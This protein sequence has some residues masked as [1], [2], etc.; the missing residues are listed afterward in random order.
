MLGSP[1][2]SSCEKKDEEG[3][4][5]LHHSRCKPRW[6]TT[7]ALGSPPALVPRPHQAIS[8]QVCEVEQWEFP[9]HAVIFLSGNRRTMWPRIP[10]R[11][12]FNWKQESR[13]QVWVWDGDDNEKMTGQSREE[14]DRGGWSHGEDGAR[15]RWK[16]PWESWTREGRLGPDSQGKL[17]G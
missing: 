11:T 10:D 6:P 8:G 15:T 9:S 3:K 4:Y 14:G 1:R 5:T 16:L 7:S 2:N 12:K 17:P 13:G